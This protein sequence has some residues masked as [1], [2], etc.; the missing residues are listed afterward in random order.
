[1]FSN[2][3]W[4]I[5]PLGVVWYLGLWV[6]SIEL[7][8]SSEPFA[9]GIPIMLLLYGVLTGS[10]QMYDYSKVHRMSHPWSFALGCVL[11][12]WTC[13]TPLAIVLLPNA[14]RVVQKYDL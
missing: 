5:L 7:S 1:M 6:A 12:A 11:W 9:A 8:A 3:G 10:I 14:H 2:R 13:L 4:L